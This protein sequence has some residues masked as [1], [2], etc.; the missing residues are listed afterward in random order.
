MTVGKI[1]APLF[2]AAALAGCAKPPYCCQEPP[3]PKAPE[4]AKVLF[5]AMQAL[6]KHAQ[7]AGLDEHGLQIALMDAFDAANRN[8]KCHETAALTAVQFYI[9]D[10]WIP[11]SD[12]FHGKVMKL[13]AGFCADGKNTPEAAKAGYE[14]ITPLVL[15]LGS[16]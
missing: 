15:N 10:K 12:A 3:P 6:E 4:E 7:A 1:L 9:G 16:H 8:P 11:S 2:L 14:S 5:E 13:L